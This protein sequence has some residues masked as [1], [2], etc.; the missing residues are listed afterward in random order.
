MV[1]KKLNI[2]HAFRILFRNPNYVGRQTVWCFAI[3]ITRNILYIFTF[4]IIQ[5][6]HKKNFILLLCKNI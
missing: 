2:G 6:G 4:V 1:E 3:Q 5:I